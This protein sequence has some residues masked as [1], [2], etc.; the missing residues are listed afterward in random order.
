[1]KATFFVLIA[2]I[3]IF[4]RGFA[5]E[6]KHHEYQVRIPYENLHFH[7]KG[8]TLVMDEYGEVPLENLQMDERVVYH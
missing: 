4:D 5:K 6:K 3:Y 2:L 7:E 1:M 8:V